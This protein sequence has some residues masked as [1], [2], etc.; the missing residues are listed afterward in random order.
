MCVHVRGDTC[1]PFLNLITHWKMGIKAL[2]CAPPQKKIVANWGTAAQLFPH[3][4]FGKYP[5]MRRTEL[6]QCFYGFPLFLLVHLSIGPVVQHSA[7]H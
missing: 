6:S 7:L 4:F 3:I 2:V 1:P 5:G